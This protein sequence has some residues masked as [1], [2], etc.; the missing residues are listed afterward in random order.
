MGRKKKKHKDRYS[1]DDWMNATPG[2]PAF[3]SRT[4]RGSTQREPSFDSRQ[5]SDS[6][7]WHRDRD[8]F[9]RHTGHPMRTRMGLPTDGD[10]YHDFAHGQDPHFAARMR[11][12]LGQSD[13]SELGTVVSSRTSPN[14]VPRT[15]RS[16]VP[17]TSPSL[18]P[19]QPQVTTGVSTDDVTVEE[20]SGTA[21][22]ADVHGSPVMWTVLMGTKVET[23]GSTP[24]KITPQ[25]PFLKTIATNHPKQPAHGST[26]GFTGAAM[27]KDLALRASRLLHS[28]D[29]PSDQMLREQVSA[30]PAACNTA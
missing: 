12:I 11:E 17:R 14:L 16:L 30:L 9:R 5:E 25:V 24:K 19:R 26:E 3:P 13:E 10:E 7:Q 27:E 8:S 6:V 22:S 1:D 23:G 18:L 29:I 28:T 20:Q 2:S 21:Q 4:P 15:C